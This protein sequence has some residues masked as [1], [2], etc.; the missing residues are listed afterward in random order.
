MI[1]D[2]IVTAIAARLTCA[3]AAPGGRWLPVT[4]GGATVG[5]V[6]PPRAARLAA[7]GDVFAVDA[8]GVAVVPALADPAARTEAF[9]GVART[10]AAEGSL[11]AWRD[12]RYAVAPAF[13]AAPLFLLERAA[14]RYFGVHCGAA[15]VNGLVDTGDAHPAMWI[16]RRSPAKAIDPGQLDNLVGGGIA[17]GATVAATVVKEAFEEAGIAAP[18]AAAARPVGCV[19]ICRA[20]PDGLHR[21]TIFV[22]DLWLPPAFVPQG[23]DAETVGHR[24][25]DLPAVARLIAQPDGPDVVTAD[26]S[27]VVLDAL[28]RHGAIRADHPDYA[29]LCALRHPALAPIVGG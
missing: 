22:H 18:L 26:A 14:A 9:A 17:A 4:A 19:H 28:L 8:A 15:H 6:E 10:L 3:L 12:E 1:E 24:R 21:E 23:Q 20:Q 7:F 11:T 5:W 13:G 27:L 25:V 2:A 16:A 29:A